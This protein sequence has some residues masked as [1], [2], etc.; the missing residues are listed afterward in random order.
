M[1]AYELYEVNKAINDVSKGYN[2]IGRSQKT[3]APKTNKWDYI[4]RKI[5]LGC[6]KTLGIYEVQNNLAFCF[7]CRKYLFPETV[8]HQDPIKNRFRSLR[9]RGHPM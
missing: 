3:L 1:N 8:Y 6:N 2:E 5:C 7:Q 4:L 9:S